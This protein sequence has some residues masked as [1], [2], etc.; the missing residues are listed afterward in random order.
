MYKVIRSSSDISNL[1]QAFE[2]GIESA[3][4][5]ADPIHSAYMALFRT[6]FKVKNDYLL[7]SQKKRNTFFQMTSRTGNGVYVKAGYNFKELEVSSD[8]TELKEVGKVHINSDRLLWTSDDINKMGLP[9][10]GT[11]PEIVSVEEAIPQMKLF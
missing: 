2:Y 1:R 7:K 8:Y 5:Y 4:G 3:E 9:I 11:C 6:L 10:D